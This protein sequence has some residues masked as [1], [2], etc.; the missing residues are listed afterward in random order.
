MVIRLKG[1]TNSRNFKEMFSVMNPS[2]AQNKCSLPSKILLLVPVLFSASSL[3]AQTTNVVSLTTFESDGR[4]RFSYPY[5]YTYG[6]PDPGGSFEQFNTFYY[7]PNDTG[8][9][10][11]MG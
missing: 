8:F 9:T 10:N 2:R 7:D 1:I 3:L 11:A 5:H 6:G 4:P